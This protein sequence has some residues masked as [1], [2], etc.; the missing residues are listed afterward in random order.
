[1]A[2]NSSGI[3][4]NR[5]ATAD[6]T[7][8]AQLIQDLV[9]QLGPLAAARAQYNVPL[10]SGANQIGVPRGT[11]FVPRTVLVIPLANFQW[12]E[13]RPPDRQFAYITTTGAGNAHLL[14]IP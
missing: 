2:G 8:L 7:E 4:L 3:V 14:F 5:L 6:T 12:F 10:V 11:G 13:T 1:M 9:E